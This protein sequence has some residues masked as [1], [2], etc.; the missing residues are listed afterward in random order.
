M[1][2]ISRR[3]ATGRLTPHGM[4]L[5]LGALAVGPISCRAG[6]VVWMMP[7]ALGD[8]ILGDD[9]APMGAISMLGYSAA[10]RTSLDVEFTASQRWAFFDRATRSSEDFEVEGI[11]IFCASLYAFCG[12]LWITF[13]GLP[14]K[15]QNSRTP[16]V[17]LLCFSWACMSVSLHVLN[18]ALVAVMH[19]P[20]IISMCQMAICSVFMT[21]TSFSKLL[22]VRRD[23]LLAWLI[24]PFFFSGMLC[25][26]FYTFEYISLSVLTIVRNLSPLVGLPIE[27]VVMP[28]DKRPQVSRWSVLAILI[29]FMGAL[30]YGNGVHNVS[31]IGIL[32]AVLNMVLA[33]SDRVLQRWLL[34]GPC[35]EMSSGV[36]TLISNFVGMLPTFCI[37]L[38]TQE[39]NKVYEEE[40][41]ERWMQPH[42]LVLLLL[43]GIVGMSINYLGF[44]CQREISATSFFVMQNVSKIAVV[45]CGIAVFDDPFNTTTASGVL[46]SIS[47]SFLY[48]RA[49]SAFSHQN[50]EDLQK[51]KQSTRSNSNSCTEKTPL[52]KIKAGKCADEDD[53]A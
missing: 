18:M 51:G 47:G 34:T 32:F 13:S 16:K 28:T 3:I 21:C 1:S 37:A 12:L 11:V 35:S 48:S 5:A 52:L 24:V 46:L 15:I 22:E 29:M 49:Q 10:S 44:E 2:V 8:F 4:R 38:A 50:T 36:C 30:V 19:A 45:I 20:A 9:S 26:S 42:F 31:V 6:T 17:T 27:L 43:S 41:L 40:R 53:S 25:S 23:Q 33:V 39:V 7:D 14:A